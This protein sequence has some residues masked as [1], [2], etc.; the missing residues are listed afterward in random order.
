MRFNWPA[1]KRWWDDRRRFWRNRKVLRRHAD[2]L[3]RR[4]TKYGIDVMDDTIE[5]CM[6]KLERNEQIAD[7]AQATQDLFAGLL[8]ESHIPDL[9]S[10]PFGRFSRNRESAGD[11]AERMVRESPD[12]QR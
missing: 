2:K 12:A 4:F 11:K 9:R 8:P 6:E 5:D 3:A 10:D 7:A 1:L